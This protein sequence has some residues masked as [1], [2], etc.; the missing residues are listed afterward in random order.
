MAN[1]VDLIPGSATAPAGRFCR[2][3]KI[4]AGE[5]RPLLLLGIQSIL[6]GFFSAVYFSTGLG[7]MIAG[8]LALW[9]TADEVS[10][11]REPLVTLLPWL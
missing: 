10:A 1:T 4:R 8:N 3:A 6:F 7:E 5:G 11:A 2:S 9:W